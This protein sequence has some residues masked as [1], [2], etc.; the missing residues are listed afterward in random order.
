MWGCCP[1]QNKYM[2]VTKSAKKAL[3]QNKKRRKMNLRRLRTMR[4]T[5]K[6]IQVKMSSQTQEDVKKLLP[7][8]YKAIDKTAKVGIIKKNT[9]ARKKSR[10]SRLVDRPKADQ[11]RAGKVKDLPQTIPKQS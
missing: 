10:L 4:G 11:P 7:K 3:R 8:A 1:I 6:D 5:I 2:P 9:A